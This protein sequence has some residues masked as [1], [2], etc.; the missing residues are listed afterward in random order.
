MNVDGEKVTNL[1]PEKVSNLSDDIDIKGLLEGSGGS[2]G[3]RML[4]PPYNLI[5]VSAE[6]P[7]KQGF[8]CPTFWWLYQLV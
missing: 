3:T 4:S 6:K 2:D 5:T 1:T 8:F 7:Q